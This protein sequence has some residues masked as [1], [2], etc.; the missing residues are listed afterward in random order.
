L[1]SSLEDKEPWNQLQSLKALTFQTGTL[2]QAQI[3]QLRLWGRVS[4]PYVPKEGY[5]CHIDIDNQEVNYVLKGG[6]LFKKYH[7]WFTKQADRHDFKW[8][9]NVIALLDHSIHELLGDEWRTLITHN[10]KVEYEGQRLKTREQ[11]EY[12]REQYR[13]EQNERYRKDRDRKDR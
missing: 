1:A 5:E 10:G 8:L 11:I 2:H 9:V 6:K 12:D 4:F 3:D 13:K 7:S